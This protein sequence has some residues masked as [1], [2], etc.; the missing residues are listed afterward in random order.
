MKNFFKLGA[1]HR[2]LEYVDATFFRP[3][4]LERNIFANKHSS[5]G[6][7]DQSPKNALPTISVHL[8]TCLNIHSSMSSCRIAPFSVDQSC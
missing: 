1:R 3:K 4:T 2:I 6:D 5:F 7:N 8:T